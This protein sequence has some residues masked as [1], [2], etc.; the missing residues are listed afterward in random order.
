MSC[1]VLTARLTEHTCHLMNLMALRRQRQRELVTPTGKA[2]VCHALDRDRR[3][4]CLIRLLTQALVDLL[5]QA[6]ELHLIGDRAA[7]VGI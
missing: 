7:V 4:W 1:S 6:I 2:Y 3:R 5:R